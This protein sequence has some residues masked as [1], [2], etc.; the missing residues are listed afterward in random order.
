MIKT[1]DVYSVVFS[2]TQDQVVQF[3]EVTGDKNL[4]HLDE[5]YA[6]KTMFKKPIL[7]GML[8]ASI[9]SK[10]FGTQFPG[11]GTIYLHQSLTFLRPMYSNQLYVCEIKVKE[12]MAAKNRMIVETRIID[13]ESNKVCIN[14]EAGVMNTDKIKE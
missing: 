13:K 11:E 6:S 14:G 1:G 2:F 9:F 4:I 12:V 8:G 10:V 3:A 7:H 5:G